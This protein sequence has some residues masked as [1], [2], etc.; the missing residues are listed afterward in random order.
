MRFGIFGAAGYVAPRHLTAMAAAGGDLVVAHDITDR[1]QILSEHFP[2]AAFFTDVELME[3]HLAKEALEG[4]LL[5]HISICSPNYLHDDHIRFTLRNGAHA[6]CEKPVVIN[7]WDLEALRETERQ[8]GRRVWTIL[9]LRLL[10]SLIALRDRVVS[11]GQGQRHEVDLTYIAERGSGYFKSW[12]GDEGLSGGIATNIGIHY[13][14]LLQWIF[15][16]V[17]EL[18]VHVRKPQVVAGTLVLD[19]ADV[20]WFLSVD[21]AHLPQPAWERGAKAL[22]SIV[23]D[24]VG[25]DFTSYPAEDLHMASYRRIVAGDGFGLDD[26]APSVEMTHDIRT[27]SLRVPG[28]TAHP[29]VPGLV[30]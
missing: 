26:A 13:F 15:G 10:P 4:R 14:D 22:R 30:A 3:R 8:H 24:G 7:P 23:V 1:P 27:S 11:A 29:L 25:L 2:A 12:K 16:P 19:R 6:I 21:A 20:R 28:V 18:R 17:Q 9:Q 5:D